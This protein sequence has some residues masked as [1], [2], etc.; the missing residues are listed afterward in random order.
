MTNPRIWSL[1]GA[2]GGVVLSL[3]VGVVDLT[4][5]GAL[6]K[7]GFVVGYLIGSMFGGLLGGVVGNMIGSAIDRKK[8]N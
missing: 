6:G 2:I 7:P 5:K 8:P 1:R 3:L 4:V